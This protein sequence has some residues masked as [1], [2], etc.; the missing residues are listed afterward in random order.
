MFNRQLFAASLEAKLARNKLSLR[1]AAR[2][3]G[4]SAS[5]LSRLLR[6]E[7]P[8]MDSFGLL[9]GWMRTRPDVFFVEAELLPLAQHVTPLALVTS[10][11]RSDEALPDEAREKLV[12][13]M[14][15]AYSCLTERSST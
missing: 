12:E 13:L 2:Q 6:C 11:L 5:T 8:D 7:L 4:V 10:A 1:E 14:K 3:C 15:V 9:C